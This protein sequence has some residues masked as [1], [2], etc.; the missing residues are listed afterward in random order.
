MAWERDRTPAAGAEVRNRVTGQGRIADLAIVRQ[1]KP[2]SLTEE[3]GYNF[4][5]GVRHR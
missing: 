1:E 4:D 5:Q 3:S 2:G